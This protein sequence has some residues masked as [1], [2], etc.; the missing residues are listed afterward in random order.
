MGALVVYPPDGLNEP[1][2]S[3]ASL[4]ALRLSRQG[5]QRL[6]VVNCR[7]AKNFASPA[8]KTK[9]WLQSRQLM[10]WSESV[11]M[12]FLGIIAKQWVKKARR[13]VESR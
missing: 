11:L 5:L 7:S 10:V 12:V 1:G 9:G 6:G 3:P 4:A 8:V 2:L 13:S